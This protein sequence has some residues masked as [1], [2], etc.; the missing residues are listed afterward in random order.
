VATTNCNDVAVIFVGTCRD[1]R[2]PASSGVER[3]VLGF[4]PKVN[5]FSGIRGVAWRMSGTLSSANAM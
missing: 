1:T 5:T 4:S 3:V 2:S